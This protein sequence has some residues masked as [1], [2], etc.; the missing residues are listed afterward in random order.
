[1]T[2]MVELSQQE[3]GTR[4]R[5]MTKRRI[6]WSD[7]WRNNY[8]QLKFLVEAVYRVLLSSKNLHTWNKTESPACPLCTARG[9]PQ[10]ILSGHSKTLTDGRYRCRHDQILNTIADKIDTAIRSNSLKPNRYT[11]NF[12]QPERRNSHRNKKRNPI[13]FHQLKTGR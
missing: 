12:I 4:W 2:K 9:S 11:I 5:E 13:Y 10:H 1:M 3:T 7:I 8:N 6:K